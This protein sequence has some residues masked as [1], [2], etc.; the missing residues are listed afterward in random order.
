[1]AAISVVARKGKEHLWVKLT[2]ANPS[3]ANALRRA[4]LA[5]LPSFA[6]D[7]VH[8]YENTSPL[9]NEYVS[10]RV[11]LVPLTWEEDVADDARIA[12][13]LQAEGPCTVYSGDLKSTD[14]VVQVFNTKIPLA[15]LG[16]KQKLRFDAFAVKGIA[17]QHAKFQCAHAAYT[18]WC[19]LKSDKKAK[20]V[21]AVKEL[22]PRAEISEDLVLKN[23]HEVDVLSLA[24]QLAAAGV[25]VKTKDDSFLFRVESYN[26]VSASQHL[27]RAV[28]LL[29][30]KC[31]ELE[32]VKV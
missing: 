12:F 4:I 25:T 19:D 22:L 18:L 7:E 28:A 10:H 9:Y 11:G 6:I 24:D 16:E 27:K 13:S 21:E 5:Y 1:M 32:D 17:R 14:E 3:F 26:N 8:F 31:G 30:Q 15:K 23:P 20:A 29:S 2:E